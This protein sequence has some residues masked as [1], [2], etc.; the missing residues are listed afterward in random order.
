M[1][2]GTSDRLLAAGQQLLDFT[3]QR[4]VVV[5]FGDE[6]LGRN[7]AAS[8]LRPIMRTG[9]NWARNAPARSSATLRGAAA[10]CS[11]SS[12]MRLI[13][14]CRAR[15]RPCAAR[16]RRECVR[17]AV[18]GRCAE[19]RAFPRA[20][21]QQARDSVEARGGLHV[22]ARAKGREA[23]ALGMHYSGRHVPPVPQTSRGPPRPVETVMVP[24]C[25]I[26]SRGKSEKGGS[27]PTGCGRVKTD[28]AEYRRTTIRSSPSRPRFV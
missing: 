3:N 18:P 8:I 20:D 28:F 27:I 22:G 7:G 9:V 1:S 16:R 2:G 10:S 17:L 15:A 23:H 5:G 26:S 14:C 13:A 11:A 19:L 4:T 25:R 24:T 6:L 12:T 21:R